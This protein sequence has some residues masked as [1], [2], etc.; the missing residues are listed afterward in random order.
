MNQNL[1]KAS[2]NLCKTVNSK[3][4]STHGVEPRHEDKASGPDVNEAERHGCAKK[5]CR[6]SSRKL[7]DTGGRHSCKM[8]HLRRISVRI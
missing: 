6:E 2:P 7:K 5:R 1:R 4:V 8:I 3:S